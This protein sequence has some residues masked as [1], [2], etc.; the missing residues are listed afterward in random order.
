[1]AQLERTR[2]LR[3]R[4]TPRRRWIRINV[5]SFSL[6]VVDGDATV[7]EMPVIV[8]RPDR[9]TPLLEGVISSVVVNPSWTVPPDLAHLD[10]LPKIRRDSR[11]L[12]SRNIDVYE[13][14]TPGARRLDPQQVDWNDIGRG[15]ETLALRQR[16]GPGN[17]LGHFLIGIADEYDV[18]L[19]DTPSRE[20]FQ[21]EIRAFSSGCIRVA[22]AR[23]LVEEILRSDPTWS[24]ER[25]TTAVASGDT[26]AL[27]VRDPMPIRVVYETAWVDGDGVVNFRDDV[28]AGPHQQTVRARP[29]PA[30]RRLAP[31]AV[32]P[33]SVRPAEASAVVAAE[34]TRTA[35]P[36]AV[37]P[38]WPTAPMHW[39][40]PRFGHG[41][42][43]AA[44]SP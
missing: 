16:S 12:A 15:I 8:G 7:L 43:G 39:G 34:S 24:P 27:E 4:P 13:S 40:R 42:V 9:P 30:P 5:P 10:L 19:H 26:V 11:Y 22:N 23:G 28:Y 44:M 41:M 32:A 14:W 31:A 3:Q 17:A 38:A 36:A 21:Q 33:P 29:A 35:R 2:R 1:V 6:A 25:L 18:F 37:T 20:L